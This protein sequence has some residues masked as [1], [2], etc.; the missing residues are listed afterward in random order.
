MS[1]VEAPA[2]G[3]KDATVR[4]PFDA[5]QE[6]SRL[7]AVPERRTRIARVPFVLILVALFGLGMAGLLLLNTTL[8]NQT[9]EARALNRQATQLAYTHDALTA[10][11]NKAAAPQ[12]L[13]RRA[14]T[15]GMRPNPVPGILVAPG[16]DVVRKAKPVTGSEVPSLVVKSPQEAAAEEAAAKARAKEK[17]A[18]EEAAARA[19]AQQAQAKEQQQD[20]NART[21]AALKK[22]AEQAQKQKKAERQARQNDRARSGTEEGTR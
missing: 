1:T 10:E 3:W 12:E 17:A 11:L 13:A 20:A 6:G 8:Q 7:H 2:A 9:F 4:S 16:G 15:L 21:Q 22:A 5:S 14:S 18:R 19:Q